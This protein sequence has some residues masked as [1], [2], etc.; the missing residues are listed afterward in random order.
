L[1]YLGFAEG[2]LDQMDED[3][4]YD[5][6]L[7]YE[8]LWRA[9]PGQFNNRGMLDSG[10]YRRGADMLAD[11]Q[12]EEANRQKR[13]IDSAANRLAMTEWGAESDYALGGLSG[14]QGRVQSLV[15]ALAD[16]DNPVGAAVGG[17]PVMTPGGYQ[18]RPQGVR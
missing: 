4:L 7:K 10:L 3:Q 1:A 2:E 11:R 16:L 17:G 8:A 14:L 15:D 9:L 5:M 13:L 6:G 12:L 18:Y